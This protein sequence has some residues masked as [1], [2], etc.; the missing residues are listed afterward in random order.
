MFFLTE[1]KNFLKRIKLIF[2][3]KKLIIFL[4]TKFIIK[5]AVKYLNIG[6]NTYR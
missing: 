4:F 5:I 1:V 3:V 2:S 6:L